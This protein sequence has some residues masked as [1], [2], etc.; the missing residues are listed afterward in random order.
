M[1]IPIRELWVDPIIILQTKTIRILWQTS[2]SICDRILVVEGLSISEGVLSCSCFSSPVSPLFLFQLSKLC[3]LFI[4]DL[5]RVISHI[6]RTRFYDPTCI[7][8]QFENSQ[9]CINTNDI[10]SGRWKC[11]SKSWK[12][13]TKTIDDRHKLFPFP[14]KCKKYFSWVKEILCVARS[15][16]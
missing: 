3:H 16:L 5:S 15:M 7:S 12:T 2:R 4:I 8:N 11:A 1:L 9:D 10:Y 6:F 14:N 13:I